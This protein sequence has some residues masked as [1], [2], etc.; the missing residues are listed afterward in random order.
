MKRLFEI[1]VLYIYILNIF[2]VKKKNNKSFE[3]NIIVIC[4]LRKVLYCF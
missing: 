2:N 3:I 1:T 4:H